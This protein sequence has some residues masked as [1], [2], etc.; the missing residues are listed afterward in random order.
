MLNKRKSFLLNL[1]NSII[2]L[3]IEIYLRGSQFKGLISLI[4]NTIQHHGS[5]MLM[6]VMPTDSESRKLTNGHKAKS[7]GLM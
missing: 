1:W 2:D 5:G 6:L 4:A 3:L 7:N